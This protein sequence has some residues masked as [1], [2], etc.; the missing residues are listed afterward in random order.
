MTYYDK[1]DWDFDWRD[2]PRSSLT[3]PYV[4]G[5]STSIWLANG[6]DFGNSAVISVEGVNIGITR[7]E[8]FTGN[9]YL[10]SFRIYQHPTGGYS[11]SAGSDAYENVSL[12]LPDRFTVFADPGGSAYIY[13]NR[14]IDTAYVNMNIYAD[15]YS[16]L[17][18]FDSDADA[19][20]EPEYDMYVHYL[21][22][23]IKHRR[24]RGGG[25]ITV[26]PDFKIWQVKKAYA[27]S[28]EYLATNIRI[29][30]SIDHLTF[31]S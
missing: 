30:P 17:L 6:R 10:S 11:A 4:Y 28:R 12:G 1:K 18:G 14:P 9:A 23:K 7:V 16:T 13:F 20:D 21:M 26:D 25:D 19:L 27:L 8:G 31:P 22:A 15:Y 24:N 29:T 2:K 3:V 5:L